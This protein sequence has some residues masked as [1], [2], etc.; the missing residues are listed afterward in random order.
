MINPDIFRFLEVW[1]AK[2]ATVPPEADAAE[3]RALF[4]TI[5][6]EMRLP[7]PEGV[8]TDEEH[9]ID[10]DGGPVRVRLFR[11][12][13]GGAQPALI[14]MHG[15]GWM[16][17]SPETHWDI[18]ARIAAWAKMTVISVDYALAPEHPY[19]AAFLQCCA[20]LR[21]AKDKA[22]DLGIDPARLAIGG[23]SAGGNLAAAVALKAREEGLALKAQLLIY[24]ACDFDRTRPSYVEN[25]EG[26]LLKVAGMARTN[27]FYCADEVQLQ[28]DPY[29][30]PLVAETHEGLPTAFVAV[31]QNDPLRDSGL[32]YSE[33]LKA[34]GV[35]VTDDPGTGLIHGYLR[36]MEYCDVAE[37][38]LKCMTDW[39]QAV[40]R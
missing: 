1:D 34:A 28:T 25:A 14:Y 38:Q 36:S 19:P 2:W 16:Q 4:E 10:S 20:V 12:N 26:P 39:L 15:G 35:S 17:G 29:I 30:A 33:A 24:P 6:S 27:A 21:W 11:H 31:A 5:A 3:R 40:L 18:T 9:W 7:T 22:K 8:N 32:A 37:T 23:D 13:S